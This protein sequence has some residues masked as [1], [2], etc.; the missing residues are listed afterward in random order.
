[1][2]VQT[3]QAFHAEALRTAYAGGDLDA[4]TDCASLLEQAGRSVVVVEGDAANVKITH[5]S[6][7]ELA[8]RS[9]AR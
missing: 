4:A 8:E 9:V 2:A 5:R 1:M 6:D 7:L 3:P